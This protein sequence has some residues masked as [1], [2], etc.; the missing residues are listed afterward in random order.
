M[1]VGAGGA[2]REKKKVYF[3][4]NI[5]KLQVSLQPSYP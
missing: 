4:G 5:D 3:G 1:L 2:S